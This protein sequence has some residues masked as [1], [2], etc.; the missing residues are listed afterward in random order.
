MRKG[1][2]NFNQQA[3]QT[4]QLE[5]HEKMAGMRT[6]EDNKELPKTGEHKHL[7]KDQVALIRAG[8]TTSATGKEQDEK[9]ETEQDTWAKRP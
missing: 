1:M 7:N 8:Q 4:K 2:G 3:T 5:K 6:H 9:L